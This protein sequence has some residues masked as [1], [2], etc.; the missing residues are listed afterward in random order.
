MLAH[1]LSSKKPPLWRTPSSRAAF[2][3]STYTVTAY[4]YM[5]CTPVSI[6]LACACQHIQSAIFV[7]LHLLTAL[8]PL[9]IL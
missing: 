8:H 5:T 6:S 4:T 1:L 7:T 2:S 3:P 9:N